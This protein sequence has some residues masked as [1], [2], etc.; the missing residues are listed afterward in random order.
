MISKASTR[1]RQ[2]FRRRFGIAAS[3]ETSISAGSGNGGHSQSTP[4]HVD[5][6]GISFLTSIA[7]GD[8]E[9]TLKSASPELFLISG[10]RFLES[11]IGI[12]AP[13]TVRCGRQTGSIR[14]E[15]RLLRSVNDRAAKRRR[16]WLHR[17]TGAIQPARRISVLQHELIFYAARDPNAFASNSR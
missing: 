16:R 12:E 14:R 5:A 17:Q 6:H 2:V 1:Q 7:S 13:Y 9:S 8:G 3:A 10:S 4:L 15:L 11:P